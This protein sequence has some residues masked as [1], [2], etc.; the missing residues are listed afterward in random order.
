VIIFSPIS[1]TILKWLRFEVVRWW[2]DFQPC[3][4]MV[5]DS[6][7]VELLWLHHIQSLANF[8]MATIGESRQIS[9]SQNFL[10]INFISFF[11]LSLRNRL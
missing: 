6:L 9:A 11:E 8:T 7:I 4:A 3:T 5:W 2:H 1:S 10:F